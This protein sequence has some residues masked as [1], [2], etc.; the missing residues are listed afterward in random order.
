[1]NAK[2][3]NEPGN[4]RYLRAWQPGVVFTAAYAFPLWIFFGELSVPVCFAS[5]V[6]LGPSS[7]F[8]LRRACRDA[9]RPIEP[10]RG[11]A[12][13]IFCAF[14]LFLL[15]FAGL[16][17]E[18]GQAYGS[19]LVAASGLFF[20]LGGWRLLFALIPAFL[21]AVLPLPPVMAELQKLSAEFWGHVEYLAVRV[22]D[23]LLVPNGAGPEGIDIAGGISIGSGFL[24]SPD[25]CFLAACISLAVP[26]LA[27]CP[28]PAAL[29][30]AAASLLL[31]PFAA[32]LSLVAEAIAA[33]HFGV[34]VPAFAPMFATCALVL[35]SAALLNGP[36]VRLASI[37]RQDRD[38][39]VAHADSIFAGVWIDGWLF[40]F[41][42]LLL[43]AGAAC[44]FLLASAP[45][46][47]P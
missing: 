10:G 9:P 13:S 26:L 2:V 12:A 31:S 29:L 20:W 30:V 32:V 41:A 17:F 11:F 19:M 8:L 23:F 43:A 40:F 22:M 4:W 33:F 7:L 15:V 39:V 16:G 6:L 24:D 42:G 35:L 1:M 38:G 27:G 14:S 28:W 18:P 37:F 36:A 34:R 5:L 25:L 46:G 47:A 44:T 21:P 3:S 45:G